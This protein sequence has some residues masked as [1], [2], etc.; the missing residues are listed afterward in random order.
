MRAKTSF[1]RVVLTRCTGWNLY[2]TEL[3]AGRDEKVIRR[4][5]VPYSIGVVRGGL[6]PLAFAV[7]FD[8][9]V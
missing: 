2:S 3:S 8:K 4:G 5:G 7:Q 1:L 6:E 9:A